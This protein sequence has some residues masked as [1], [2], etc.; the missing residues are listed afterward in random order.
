MELGKYF[1]RWLGRGAPPRG[2]RPKVRLIC[3]GVTYDVTD[4]LLDAGVQ[5]NNHHLWVV[6]GP[7][8]VRVRSGGIRLLTR[9]LPERTDIEVPVK[10]TDD[11]AL[12]FL[13]MAEIRRRF[14][15]IG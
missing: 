2:T 5:E 3:E 10:E 13:T 12:R 15:G 14:P 4:V 6:L 9:L 1:S 8:H 7:A 11:G